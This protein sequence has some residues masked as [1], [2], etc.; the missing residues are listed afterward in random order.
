MV[1]SPLINRWL[2]KTFPMSI[3]KTFSKSALAQNKLQA[4]FQ[5]LS[6]SS[7][8]QF[9]CRKN[10]FF[11]GKSSQVYMPP[12]WFLSSFIWDLRKYYLSRFFCRFHIFPDFFIYANHVGYSL[13]VK[14]CKMFRKI[15]RRPEIKFH[16][17]LYIA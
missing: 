1:T 10:F 13:A 2:A 4:I 3:L 8:R 14:Y 11:V 6:R 12:S 16:F 9:S 17:F 15:S 5:R 7:Q